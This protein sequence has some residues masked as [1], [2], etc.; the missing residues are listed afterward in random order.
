MKGNLRRMLLS[1]FTS[2]LL[3]ALVLILV[4]FF[5]YDSD[6]VQ[7]ASVD[8]PMWTRE[9]LV[10]FI[11]LFAGSASAL[12]R[13]IPYLG[14]S[15]ILRGACCCILTILVLEFFGEYSAQHSLGTFLVTH[16]ALFTV[17][18]IIYDWDRLVYEGWRVP[19]ATI[20]V[21]LFGLLILFREFL[22][23]IAA[24]ASRRK[25]AVPEDYPD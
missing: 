3:L 4:V 12:L 8:D 23:D 21:P 9:S 18:R 15:G 13:Y 16:P 10:A 6:W 7:A 25:R 20:F 19:Y 2:W 14:K 5:I 24:R 1:E 22:E 11:L 17:E